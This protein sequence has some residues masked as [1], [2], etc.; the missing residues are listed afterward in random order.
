MDSETIGSVE[1]KAGDKPGER[2]IA[3]IRSHARAEMKNLLVRHLAGQPCSCFTYPGLGVFRGPSPLKNGS[4]NG[5]AW[6][7]IHAMM[8]TRR[9]VAQPG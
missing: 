4:P 7:L 6:R 3:K 1:N 9:S 2:W 5:L 8:V